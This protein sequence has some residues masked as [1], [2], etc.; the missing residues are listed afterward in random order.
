MSLYSNLQRFTRDVLHPYLIALKYYIVSELS[1]LQILTNNLHTTITDFKND[2]LNEIQTFKLLIQTSISTSIDTFTKKYTTL[3]ASLITHAESKQNPHRITLSQ[4]AFISTQVPKPI[5]GTTQSIWIQYSSATPNYLWTT[6]EWSACSVSCGGGIQT[7]T[8]RCLDELNTI[9]SDINCTSLGLTKPAT[10]RSCNTHPCSINIQVYSCVDDGGTLYPA[11][12]AG[13]IIGPAQGISAGPMVGGGK[14][15]SHAFVTYSGFL[16]YG[17]YY[18]FQANITNV[19]RDNAGLSIYWPDGTSCQLVRAIQLGFNFYPN[20]FEQSGW[21]H[22]GPWWK[23][24]S[25]GSLGIGLFRI[26]A[27]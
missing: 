3:T 19:S 8:V 5:D 4:I 6:G 11:D 23:F 17:G 16:N 21:V 13:N 14:T 9:V 1:Y 22:P 20:G 2:I 12:A 18:Y 26:V 24:S 10:S 15:Y 7:R 25:G 27:R